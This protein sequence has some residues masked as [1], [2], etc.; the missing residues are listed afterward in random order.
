MQTLKEKKAF[1]SDYYKPAA[2]EVILNP[3]EIQGTGK[4]RVDIFLKDRSGTPYPL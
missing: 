2:T 4:E 3:K 1:R